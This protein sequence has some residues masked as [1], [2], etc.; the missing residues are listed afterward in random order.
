MKDKEKTKKTQAK[1]TKL[2]RFTLKYEDGMNPLIVDIYNDGYVRTAAGAL[3]AEML[4]SVS[5][6]AELILN[7][8]SVASAVVQVSKNPDAV[9]AD[10]QKLLI[11]YLRGLLNQV[12]GAAGLTVVETTPEET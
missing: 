1:R 2:I 12:A 6:M 5:H 8:A 3:P 10:T 4:V 7:Q 9:T 11:P